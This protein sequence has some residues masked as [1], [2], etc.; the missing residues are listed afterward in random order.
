MILIESQLFLD[1]EEIP[2]ITDIDE[3]ELTKIFGFNIVT[4]ED[5]QGFYN[6]KIF[7]NSLTA[8]R[9]FDQVKWQNLGEVLTPLVNP[10]TQIPIYDPKSLG[11]KILE[12]NG[13]PFPSNYY[14][15]P[16]EQMA[17]LAGGGDAQGPTKN[18]KPTATQA[19]KQGNENQK[20]LGEI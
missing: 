13:E 18:P 2:K 8:S 17:Q 11:D 6:I 20:P 3:K 9:E 19:V 15:V 7:A 1:R 10:Q 4:N 14:Y 5:I 16:D 12:S